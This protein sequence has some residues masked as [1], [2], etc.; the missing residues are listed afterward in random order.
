MKNNKIYLTKKVKDK[1]IEE[2]I[3]TISFSPNMLISK[4]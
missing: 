4:I 1:K 2:K 3:K